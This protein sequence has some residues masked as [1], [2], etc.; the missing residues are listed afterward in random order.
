M[1]VPNRDAHEADLARVMGRVL[2]QQFAVIMAALGEAPSLDKLTP[3]LFATMQSAVQAA[4]RP[5]LEKVYLE[6]AEALTDETIPRV[7]QGGIGVDWGVINQR[8]AEWASQY[9]FD[10]V[11]G[12][13]N[14]TRATLQKQVSDFSTDSRTLKDLRQSLE[15]LFGPVRAA[16]IAETE[17]TR[18]ASEGEQAFGDELGKLG[19]Q[20]DFIWVTNNDEI[21][22]RCPI[23]W[24]RHEKRRGDGWT[25]FPPAHPRC[26]CWVNTVVV[27]ARAADLPALLTA[28]RAKGY[29][30][31][32]IE[33]A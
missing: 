15:G 31:F 33:A 32:F 5:V 30:G 14:T 19:L 20:V 26:R 29:A 1:D 2:R 6:Q 17:V 9:S 11:S 10:L 7:K 25:D 16:M 13:V 12:I 21:V 4:I 27:A 28:A 24:P 22:R 3:E 23:C 18:A 8:A